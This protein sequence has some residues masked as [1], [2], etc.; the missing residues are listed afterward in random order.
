MKFQRALVREGG[1]AAAW[2]RPWLPRERAV[3]CKA[4]VGCCI[5]LAFLVVIVV[6]FLAHKV[7]QNRLASCEATVYSGPAVA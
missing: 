5:L 7:G 1:A 2:W 4:R 3:S 6:V